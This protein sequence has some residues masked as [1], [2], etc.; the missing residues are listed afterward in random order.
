[1]K[2]EHDNLDR[3]LA[4]LDQF[5]DEVVVYDTGS[6]DDTREIARAAGALVVEGD[7][8]GDFAR[9]RNA[10]LDH[11]SGEWVLWI[12]AD[13]ALVA[14]GPAQRAVLEEADA[15]V[16]AFVVMI[17]NLRGAHA[18]TTFSHPACRIFRRACGRWTGKLHEQVVARAGTPKLEM[19]AAEGIRLAHWGYLSADFESRG[20][21]QRNLASSFSDLAASSGLSWPSR[22]VNLARSYSLH[23]HHEEAVDLARAAIDAGT[24][25]AVQRLALRTIIG[26]L[27]GLDRG[28]DALGAA[29][30]LRRISKIPLLADLESGR[31]LVSLGRNEEALE[32]L[33][34]VL[35]GVDD[36]GFEYDAHDV[37]VPKATALS[38]LGRHAEAAD[39]LLSTIIEHG[40]LDVHVGTLVQCLEDAGRPLS[41][42][43]RA[44]PEGRAVAFLGQLPQL[45]AAVADRVLEPWHELAPSTAVLATAAR[46]ARSLP[47]DRREVWSDRLRATGLAHACPLVTMSGPPVE[48]VTAA[49]LAV[50][51]Y[52]DPRGRMGVVAL[53]QCL[54][55]DARADARRALARHAPTVVDLFDAVSSCAPPPRSSIIDADQTRT[56][57]PCRGA[58]RRVLVVA[59]KTSIRAMALAATLRRC[60]HVV[61]LV[62]PAV[63]GAAQL[64]G[65]H[66]VDVADLRSESCEAEVARRYAA[67][68]FDTVVVTRFGSRTS[69][70]QLLPAAALVV[71][72]DDAAMPAPPAD[73][74]L[75][76]APG[77]DRVVCQASAPQLFSPAPALPLPLVMREG[78]CVVGD[79]Q[80]ATP[81]ELAH[82]HDAVLPALSRRLGPAPVAFLG[83]DDGSRMLPGALDLGALADPLPWLRAARAVLVACRSGAEHWLAAAQMC[84]TPA[85]AVPGADVGQLAQ[86]VAALCDRRMDELWARVAPRAP[87]EAVAPLPDPLAGLP[88]HRDM[89][90]ARARWCAPGIRISERRGLAVA[91]LRWGYGALPAE[92]VG[93]IRDLA[94]EVRVPTNWARAHALSSGVAPGKVHVVGVEVDAEACS[95]VGPRRALATRKRT[96]LLYLGDCSARSGIDALL[97]S[98]FVEFDERDSVCLVVAATADASRSP[99]HAEIQK[100][101]SSSGHPE[102]LLVD[103]G[104]AASERATLY[105][106]CDAFVCP[107]RAQGDPTTLLEA[108]AYGLPAVFLAGGA[109]DDLC[110]PDAGYP[111]AAR[112][113]EVAPRDAGVLAATGPMRQLE[114]SRAALGA[115]LREAAGDP[116]GR[117]RRGDAARRR[118]LKQEPSRPD[119]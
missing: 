55:E 2:D 99:L 91:D 115:A 28:E 77:P 69:L 43:A 60:G 92:W 66:G 97:E 64:L 80:A 61:T 78:L 8:D 18:S 59:S 118:V 101:T 111:V 85:L 104:A 49:A 19:A 106:A 112:E 84:G 1:V 119:T 105:R 7:W 110:G 75:A 6:T 54:G 45:E 53:T 4:S 87:T 16:E 67:R 37:A 34:R 76:A 48:A 100:A 32:A 27:L 102:V 70:R 68:R 11:C 39:V 95:P 71:D 116:G 93:P 46:V 72:L 109:F 83:D 90:A 24:T 103:A 35:P 108:M 15:V 62:Q 38:R 10:A 73:L 23:G 96:K 86:A 9:A 21:A 56:P 25:P 79:F 26:A 47:L 50:H 42:I 113:V 36:D 94:D 89:T 44:V 3:C 13:E 114:P 51:R 17:D 12:D 81:E 33:S 41:E 107:E 57:D 40:G 5:C 30:E 65:S 31:A 58:S 29:D 88:Q 117:K 20:K 82:L 74:V 63:R 98:F 22:L 52:D 14:D